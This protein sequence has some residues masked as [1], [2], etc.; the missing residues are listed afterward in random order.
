MTLIGSYFDIQ[1]L[2]II[3]P[4]QNYEL[5]YLNHYQYYPSWT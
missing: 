1:F 2:A 5:I 4:K 3:I